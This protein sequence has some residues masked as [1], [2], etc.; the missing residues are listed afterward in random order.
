MKIMVVGDPHGGNPHLIPKIKIAGAAGITH[1]VV[2]GD[3]GLWTHLHDG[4][5]FLDAVQREAEDNNLSVFF[6]GG[7]HENWDHWEWFMANMPKARGWAYIR[8][9]IL[10]APKVHTWKWADKQFVSAGGAVSV[11]RDHRLK[12]E[13]GYKYDPFEDRYTL[14]RGTTL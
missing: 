1:I 11:D 8:S 13:A 10:I 7:N 14:K 9:R 12:M 2:V 5:I 4:H 3:C 6:I